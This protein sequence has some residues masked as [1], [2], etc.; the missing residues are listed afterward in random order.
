MNHSTQPSSD[1]TYY[2]LRTDTVYF[3]TKSTNAD[4]DS[5]KFHVSL[6]LG[7]NYNIYFYFC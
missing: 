6:Y 4:I 7:T 5:N 2:I 3:S 1:F